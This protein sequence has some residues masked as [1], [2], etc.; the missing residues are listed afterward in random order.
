MSL[1]RDIKD[2]VYIGSSIVLIVLVILELISIIVATI[3][4][5]NIQ[6]SENPVEGI[7]AFLYWIVAWLL[8]QLYVI[9]ITVIVKK[10]N[11][12]SR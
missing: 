5:L 12:W 10:A 8:Q 1:K 9:P 3:I 11:R 7:I 6:N 2:G 4:V